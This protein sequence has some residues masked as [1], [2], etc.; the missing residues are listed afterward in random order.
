MGKDIT[1]DL[2]LKLAVSKSIQ[3]INS[4]NDLDNFLVLD[5]QKRRVIVWKV[6]LRKD[7]EKMKR[8]HLLGYYLKRTNIVKSKEKE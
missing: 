4:N 6:V 5:L 7:K 8:N 3:I 2:Q 1:L